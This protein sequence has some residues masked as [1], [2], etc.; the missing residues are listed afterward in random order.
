[1]KKNL[2]IAAIPVIIAALT[3]AVLLWFFITPR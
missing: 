1:M 3:M 2:L